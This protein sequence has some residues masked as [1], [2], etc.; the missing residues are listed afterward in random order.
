MA[1]RKCTRR[2][3]AEPK[4]QR[5]AM[6]STGSSVVSSSRWAWRDALAQQPL[7]RRRAGGRRGS[8][9]RTCGATS[10]A[11]RARSLDGERLVEVVDGPVEGGRQRVVVG[12]GRAPARRRTATGRRR[13][14]RPRPCGG[15]RRWPPRRRGRGA[16]CAGT[17]RCRR[18]CRPTC[19]CRRRR[20]RRA[21]RGRRRSAGTGRA[22]SS[23]YIQWVVAERPSS[24]PASASRN[25]PE[26][27]DMRRAPRPVGVAER[28]RAAPVGGAS[29]A[30]LPRRHDDGVGG[31]EVG[32]APRAWRSCS[33]RR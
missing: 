2:A 5:L 4:P 10:S 19:R 32:E 31:G 14:A 15:R 29:S 21:P 17:G 7:Q 27:T 26:H 18:R 6:I 3:V 11:R 1:R 8:G 13:G 9:G 33:R 23:V 30:E 22:S 25:A 24:R 16:R 12:L 20:R 28:V